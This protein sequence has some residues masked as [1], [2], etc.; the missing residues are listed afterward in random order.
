[1]DTSKLLTA[2]GLIALP[3]QFYP[4]FDICHIIL[5]VL[6]IRKEAGRASAI[7]KPSATLVSAAISSFAGS[8]LA[9][10]LLGTY[11]IKD[12]KWL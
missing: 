1:M 7:E 8:L 9:N 12:T 3:K 2:E 5:C 10:P 6:S 4:Y 11:Q